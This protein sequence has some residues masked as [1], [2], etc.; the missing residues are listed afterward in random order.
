MATMLTFPKEENFHLSKKPVLIGCMG[1]T[2]LCLCLVGGLWGLRGLTS[3]PKAQGGEVI[4][5]ID[6]VLRSMGDRDLERAYTC[7]STRAKRTFPMADLDRFISGSNFAL[8]DGYTGL[9]ISSMNINR[10]TSSNP[11]AP[12]GLVARVEGYLRYEDHVSGTFQA[13]LEKEGGL[14]KIYSIQIDPPERR[15]EDG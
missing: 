5:A 14:W 7:F 13:V 3:G 2:V 6:G 4:D 12:Q 10:V 1:I 9:V 15:K 11:D 8:V